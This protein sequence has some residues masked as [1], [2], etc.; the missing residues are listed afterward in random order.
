M[1]ELKGS[2]KLQVLKKADLQ[3]NTGLSALD[4]VLSWFAQ[5]YEQRIPTSVWIRCQLALAEG[6]TNAVRHAH[7]GLPPDLPVEIE[8][9]VCTES[10]EI[11]I[12]DSGA[13][14]DL[15]QKIKYMSQKIDT[16]ASGGRGLKLMKDIADSLSYT[17]TA[18]GRNCLSIVKNY[19]P[20][21][22]PN[23]EDDILRR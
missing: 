17:R 21:S 19:T 9:V 10:V 7:E 22:R 16:E 23:D 6:F 12:W 13:A 15:E 3:V 11:K 2:E 20:V 4:R 18:D 14:F 8:V 5:L 1:I